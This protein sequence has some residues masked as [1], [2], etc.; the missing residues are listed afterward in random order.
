MA[1]TR[2][3]W[4]DL[5]STETPINAENLNKMDEGIYDNSLSTI[6][7]TIET[8]IGT[9]INGK[10]LYRKVI[11]LTEEVQNDTVYYH[12][13]DDI[14]FIYIENAFVYL[15]GSNCWPLPIDLYGIG[16]TTTNRIG[17]YA[18]P[19]LIGFKCDT[20]WGSQWNKVVIIR[21]TKRSDNV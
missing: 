7:S 19:L 3:N 9:W 18:N 10:P 4:E 14:D 2:V 16:S 20:S 5:P 13:I 17:V 12:H 6:Y 21:Y 8:K 1:Y 11:V 15:N